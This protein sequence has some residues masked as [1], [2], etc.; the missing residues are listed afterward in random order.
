[1]SG[2]YGGANFNAKTG[3]CSSLSQ[4]VF[5]QY[6]EDGQMN[7]D[8][9]KRLCEEKGYECE[10]AELEA[11]FVRFDQKETG[12]LEYKEF[13]QWWKTQ[14]ECGDRVEELKFQSVEQKKKV[15]QARKSFFQETGGSPIMTRE[16]FQ[17]RCYKNGYCLSE[18]ELD[19]AMAELD[20]DD[21]GYVEFTE[22]LRWR[23]RD[24]R[25]AHLQ[26]DESDQ[27]AAYVRQ[28]SD[29]FKQYDEELTGYLTIEQFTPLWDSLVDNGEVTSSLEDCLAEVDSDGDGRISLNEFLKWYAYCESG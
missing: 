29:F 6:S 23:L 5:D 10:E 28:V 14:D 17:V 24:D 21:S 2:G 7:V 20:K 9:L 26:H 25:F 1:M 11:A 13:L 18:E 12:Y 15:L 8:D 4:I 16:Q 22:Y 19:E 3:Q 27:T